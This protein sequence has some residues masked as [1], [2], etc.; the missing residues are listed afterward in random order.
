MKKPCAYCKE[1]LALTKEHVWPKGL[2]KRFDPEAL[3]YSKNTNRFF[4]SDLVVKDVCVECNN[5]KLSSLDSYLCEIFDSTFHEFVAPGCPARINYNYDLLLRGLLKISFNSARTQADNLE[6]IKAHDRFSGY[7]LDGGYRPSY[8][9]LR[10]LIVTS[11][12]Q[13]QFG[14]GYIGNFEP[15][16]LRCV[17]INYD[18]P[19]SA[20]FFVRSV[21]IRS[22]WFYIIISKRK[23]SK[24]K[25]EQFNR[26]FAGWKIQPGKLLQPGIHSLNI[27]AS[28][29][30][31]M[32]EALL[33]SLVDAKF[34]RP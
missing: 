30:T 20:R 23:E 21:V 4:K 31:Y 25:W 29:T 2:I 28:E 22:Y 10:L 16:L 26:A 11:A 9:Q 27:P 24:A 13:L 33:G 15:D 7:I 5:V 8:V 19:L 17:D 32:H 12:K 6:K 18:G 14:K 34:N 1:N 3:T